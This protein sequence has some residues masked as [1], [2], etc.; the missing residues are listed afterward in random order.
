MSSLTVNPYALRRKP[1]GLSSARGLLLYIIAS[2]ALGCRYCMRSKLKVRV[3]RGHVCAH[4]CF[5]RDPRHLTARSRPTRCVNGIEHGRSASRFSSRRG[6]SSWERAEKGTPLPCRFV[7]AVATSRK[8][9]DSRHLGRD[10]LSKHGSAE[11]A[12]SSTTWVENS[13]II[14]DG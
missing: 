9:Y 5:A 1:Q 7:F 3:I 11:V 10:T 4:N 14:V 12:S 13:T 6:V 8:R 2:V